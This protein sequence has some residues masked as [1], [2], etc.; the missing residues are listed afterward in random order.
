ML[1]E[2]LG[3]MVFFHKKLIIPSVNQTVCNVKENVNIAV[4][5]RLKELQLEPEKNFRP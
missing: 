3:M 2:L 5:Q 4:M 1:S